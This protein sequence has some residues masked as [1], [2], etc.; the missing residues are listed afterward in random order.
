MAKKQDR[1]FKWLKNYFSDHY[2][3]V[4]KVEIDGHEEGPDLYEASL[5]VKVGSR[6]FFVRKRGKHLGEAL[7]RARESMGEKI[8]RFWAKQKQRPTRESVKH[9]SFN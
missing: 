4:N 1:S 5:K 2:P 8:R 3:M 9:N 6:W 7:K